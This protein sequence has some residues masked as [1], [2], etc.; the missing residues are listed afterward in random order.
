MAMRSERHPP[1][2]PAVL[3][4]LVSL[5]A[6]EKHGY[7]LRKDVVS[8]SGGRVRLGPATLYRTLAFLLEDGAIEESG[9]RPVPELDDERRR[10]YRLTDRGRRML[11]SEVARLEQLAASARAILVQRGKA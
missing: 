9:R 5:A 3:F 10:Y 7:A 4:L 2:K 8:R 6:G 1:L 11:R